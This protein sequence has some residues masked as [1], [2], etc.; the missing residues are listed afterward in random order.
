MTLSPKFQMIEQDWKKWAHNALV[1]GAPALVALIASGVQVVPAD[2]KYGVLLLYLLN[3]A[4][5]FLKKFISEE[6]YK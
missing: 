1:F 3:L 6:K 5:D 2:W 4:T